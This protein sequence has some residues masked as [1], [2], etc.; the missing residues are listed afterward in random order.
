MRN[1]KN[2]FKMFKMC[3]WNAVYLIAKIKK[4][5]LRRTVVRDNLVNSD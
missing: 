1:F 4:Y 2:K 3:L 5:Y